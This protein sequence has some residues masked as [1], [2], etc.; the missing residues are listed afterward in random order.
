MLLEEQFFVLE[1]PAACT[2]SSFDGSAEVAALT[3][4]FKSRL[5]S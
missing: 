4:V 3:P 2:Q 1:V 5:S